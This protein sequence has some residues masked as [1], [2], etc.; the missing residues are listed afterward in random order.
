M[1]EFPDF[2]DLDKKE[3]IKIVCWV[4][5]IFFII[6]GILYIVPY[7]SYVIIVF[8]IAIPSYILYKQGKKKK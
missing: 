3:I 2:E 1:W 7:L 8:G 5:L 4:I 6:V